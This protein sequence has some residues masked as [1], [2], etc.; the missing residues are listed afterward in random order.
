M[1]QKYRSLNF[2]SSSCIFLPLDS[3]FLYLKRDGG[4]LLEYILVENRNVQVKYKCFIVMKNVFSTSCL[5]F[6]T[7]TIDLFISTQLESEHEMLLP[8]KAVRQVIIIWTMTAVEASLTAL[9]TAG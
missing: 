5:V 9:Y 7:W 8:T 6:S 4:G 3:S 2:Y 1:L